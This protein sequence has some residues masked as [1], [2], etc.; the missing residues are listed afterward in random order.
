MNKY[1]C[2]PEDAA[3]IRK[4]I[5]TRG[6]LLQWKSAN[7]ANPGATW[8]TPALTE[9]GQPY[10]KPI[11]QCENKPERHITSAAEVEVVVAREVK[12]FRVGTKLSSSGMQ[13]KVTDA[14]SRKIRDEVARAGAGAYH[15]FDYGTQEAVIYAPAKVVPLN[16]WG[17]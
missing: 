10:A 13:V 14:G 12:R 3:K 5:D 17:Q 7:L 11:W 9:D 1:Q 4:W 16:E 15:E 2:R 6:G 8:T